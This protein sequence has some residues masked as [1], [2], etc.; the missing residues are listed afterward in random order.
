MPA[1][2]GLDIAV[3]DGDR[4]AVAFAFHGERRAEML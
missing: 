1:H 2:V 3:R 4:T